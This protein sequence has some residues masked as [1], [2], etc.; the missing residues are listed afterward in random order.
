MENK[1][2]KTLLKILNKISIN[3]IDIKINFIKNYQK[4]INIIDSFAKKIN[5]L[6][7]DVSIILFMIG[8]KNDKKK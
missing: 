8:I 4:E 2:Y 3:G 5:N 7:F 6:G 1:F